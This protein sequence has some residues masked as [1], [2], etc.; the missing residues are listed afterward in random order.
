MQLLVI[1]HAIAADRMTFDGP[2]ESRPLTKE[3]RRRMRRGAAGL[4][5]EIDRVAVLATS[6][7]LRAVKTAK[8]VAKA[9][10]V[11]DVEVRDE[12]VPDASPADTLEW[13]RTREPKTKRI[14]IVG[15]EPHLGRLAGWLLAG[16]DGE[17]VLIKKGAALLLDLPRSARP[18]RATLLW[19]L[20]P[21]QLRRLGR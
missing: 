11:G 17:P 8:I 14:A 9:I 3:G 21:R 6:P 12:L 20:T 7:L 19:S 1:R 13:L 2:D 5:T 10:G 16:R 15:H 18:G 4:A